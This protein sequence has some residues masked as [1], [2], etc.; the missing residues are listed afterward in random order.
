MVNLYP[1]FQTHLIS[2]SMSHMKYSSFNK[3]VDLEAKH[4]DLPARE[5]CCAKLQEDSR[6]K[7][8]GNEG[9]VS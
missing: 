2:V 8:G 5:L 1:A 3:N 6:K 7:A 4:K 9:R